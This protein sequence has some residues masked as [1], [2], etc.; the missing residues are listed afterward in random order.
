MAT[1]SG[2]Y[3]SCNQYDEPSCDRKTYFFAYGPGFIGTIV[4]EDGT[5]TVFDNFGNL[6]EVIGTF[7]SVTS[8]STTIPMTG[9]AYLAYIHELEDVGVEI[10]EG[11]D[12]PIWA[13][14]QEYKL[15]KKIYSRKRDYKRPVRYRRRMMFS[16]SG[17]LL[18]NG[19]LK[20]KGN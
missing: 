19:R 9:S 1:T 6:L 4:E 15:V 18:K 11:Y 13:K 20:R 17:W 16:M 8:V 3:V 5:K 7:E 2:T 14:K 10:V 12:P